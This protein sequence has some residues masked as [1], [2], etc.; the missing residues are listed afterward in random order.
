MRATIPKRVQNHGLHVP[1]WERTSDIGA[2][3]G[4]A[5]LKYKVCED[6]TTPTPEL[7]ASDYMINTRN[8]CDPQYTKVCY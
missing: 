1:R 6:V 7:H 8:A 3:C 2:N 4:E 5:I